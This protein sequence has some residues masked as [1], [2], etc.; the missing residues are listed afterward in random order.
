MHAY[1]PESDL[2]SPNI[3]ILTMK[4]ILIWLAGIAVIAAAA[5][6]AWQALRPA[7]SAALSGSVTYRERVALPPGSVVEVELRDVSLADAPATVLAETV[8]TTAGENVPIPFELAYSPRDIREN[9]S[10]A[11]F[12]RILVDGELRWSTDAHIPVLT[13]GAP[14]TD[15]N[16]TLVMVGVSSELGASSGASAVALLGTTFRLMS[17]GGEA[18]PQGRNYTLSFEE[19][20]ISA[21]FC[22][23]LAGSYVLA[24]SILSAPQMV[25]T[26]MY[27]E[28]PGNPMELEGAFARLLSEGAH[29]LLSG[30]TLALTGKDGSQM[31]FTVFTD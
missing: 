9:L 4:D 1:P 13:R 14:A 25:T 27:C 15:I 12:A 30:S 16:A 6:F 29:F 20:R 2:A 21:Q 5:F 10:Y 19:G 24:E 31:I 28:G 7:E 26:E 11:L 18:I 8:I 3:T 22:N 17:Y 23:R